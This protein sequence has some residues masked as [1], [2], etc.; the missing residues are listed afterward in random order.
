MLLDN[1]RSRRADKA[2]AADVQKPAQPYKHVCITSEQVDARIR[3]LQAACPAFNITDVGNIALEPYYNNV[4]LVSTLT[5]SAA[6]ADQG[7]TA[8]VNLQT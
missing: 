6:L 1:I 4:P 7:E 8:A 5:P 2:L 3:T